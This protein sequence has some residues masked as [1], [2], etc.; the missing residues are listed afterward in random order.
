[1]FV[2][3]RWDLLS[4][5]KTI[6]CRKNNYHLRKFG[7]DFVSAAGLS[8][9]GDVNQTLIVSQALSKSALSPVTVSLLMSPWETRLMEM[10]QPMRN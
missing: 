2:P 4:T 8:V 10:K 9:S 5:G 6:F 7:G 3:V 1:M